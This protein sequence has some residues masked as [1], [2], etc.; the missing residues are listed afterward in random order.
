MQGRREELLAQIALLMK[1]S[2]GLM[3]KEELARRMN[4]NAAYLCRIIKES[5]GKSFTQ[6]RLFVRLKAAETLLTDSD[7][8]ITEIC[9]KLQFTN[10]TY[11]YKAFE[12]TFGVTPNEFR[13]Q[14]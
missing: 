10:R 7:L 8:T 14:R 12:Q 5:L 13:L 11:F 9:E 2:M 1:S 3:T 6:Y 4:Y